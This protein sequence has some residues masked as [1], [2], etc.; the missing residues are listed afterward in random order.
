MAGQFFVTFATI[1]FMKTRQAFRSYLCSY[2]ETNRAIV[3]CAW[4]G[5]KVRLVSVCLVKIPR[6]RYKGQPVN[7]V[8]NNN[9]CL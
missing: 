3:R 6:P 7:S 5:G 1:D 8:D 2:R 9:R 4:E